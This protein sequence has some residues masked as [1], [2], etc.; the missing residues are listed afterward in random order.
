ME[1][2]KQPLGNRYQLKLKGRLDAYWSEHLSKAI[3]E[4][5][6]GGSHEIELDLAGVDYLSS[7]GIRVLI[8][9][10]KQLKA[11]DGNLRIANPSEAAAA[12]LELAGLSGL[13]IAGGSVAQATKPAEPRRIEKENAVYYAYPVASDSK[14]SCAL[15]GDPQKLQTSGYSGSDSKGVSFP[16]STFGVG[17]GAFGNDF[18][19]CKERYG[20]F[21]AVEGVAA[22]LPTDGTN[23]PDFMISE[24]LLVPQLEVLYGITAQGLFSTLLRFEAKAEPP[25]VLTLSELMNQ[26]VEIEGD[27]PLG[28]VIVAES[29][30]LVG[31]SLK[32][33]PVTGSNP[34]FDFPKVRDWLNFT[35]ERVYDRTLCV[36]VGFISKNVSSGLSSVLRP[37]AAESNLLGHLHAAVFPYRPLQRGDI[38]L[39]QTINSMF[40]GESIQ[41]LM[42]LLADD[43]EFEGI[44]QSEFLRGACW[45]GKIGEVSRT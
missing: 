9:F 17:I 30:G 20:E 10:Y 26:A 44:G 13:L 34:S 29:A 14:L 15:V 4:T 8:K 12:I 38:N 36:A 43:R 16:E 24:G 40:G 23:V 45:I 41:G 42:H 22:Y 31:A 39:R 27:G 19:E 32:K 1:I 2:V 3:E 7:A 21:I 28:I 18:N 11:I 35:P 5:I 6:H 33:S 37:L 25:G